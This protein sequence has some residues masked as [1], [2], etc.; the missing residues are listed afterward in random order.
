MSKSN[1]EEFRRT[2]FTKVTPRVVNLSEAELVKTSYL[3]LGETLPLVIEPNA[4]ELDFAKWAQNNLKFIEAQL[5]KH[6]AILFRNFN[7]KAVSKFEQAV[8][9]I[10]PELMEY[11]ERSTPRTELAKN[12][13]T[14]T[15]YPAHQTI[16]LHNE[17]SYAH[18]W[19]MKLW[20]FCA[21][22]ATEGGETPIADSR[23]VFELLDPKIRERF[24]QKKI[25]YVRNYGDGIDLPWQTVFQTR[26]V[27]V[28][29]DYC[30][31]ASMEFEWKDGNRLRTR[32]V[33]PAIKTHPKT[34]ET[35]W[36]NQAH[37]FHVSNLSPPVRESL[38]A[39]F[40]EEDLPRNTFYGDGSAIESSVLDEIRSVLQ[41]LAVVFR[42]QEGDLLMLDNMLVAHGRKPFTGPRKI[43][44]AMAEPFVSKTSESQ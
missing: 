14:A 23:R 44:V 22:A 2:A 35:V 34:G 18:Q 38:L 41:Q 16:A 3:Q 39:L 40:K 15:E 32:H 9:S 31:S 28:V 17:N 5:L 30:R 29:E 8:L 13:Y 21:L 11:Q 26:E 10:S 36:F 27:S 19:P 24:R 4:A 7:I 33:R 25:M 43:M 6:G 20:F 12:I 37:L 42:W 1:F